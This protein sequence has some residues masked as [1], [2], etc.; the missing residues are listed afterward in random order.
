MKSTES[1]SCLLLI[2]VALIVIGSM[3][4]PVF[5]R[6]LSALSADTFWS[7]YYF[8]LET[9]PCFMCLII[10]KHS[11]SNKKDRSCSCTVACETRSS[12][13]RKLQLAAFAVGDRKNSYKFSSSGSAS[14]RWIVSSQKIDVTL[15][16]SI[17]SMNSSGIVG[18][19]NNY[20]L[21]HSMLSAFTSMRS[22]CS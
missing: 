22:S 10:F 18:W 11:K 21:D 7:L 13:F 3:N 17:G 9:M 20:S 12:D 5:Q 19:S 2:R 14:A 8:D 16:G 1:K 15:R 6:A 4:S